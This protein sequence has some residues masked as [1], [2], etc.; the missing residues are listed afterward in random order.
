[1]KF[2]PAPQ[3]RAIG[4]IASEIVPDKSGL[5][6][7]FAAR[8]KTFCCTCFE[9]VWYESASYLSC[10]AN[11]GSSQEKITLVF[12]TPLNLLLAF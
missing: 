2:C 1:M 9:A 3:L 6:A 4:W 10:H 12:T 8:V 11:P 5:G 7:Y